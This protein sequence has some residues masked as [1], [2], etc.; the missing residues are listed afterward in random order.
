MHRTQLLLFQFLVQGL[1]LKFSIRSKRK[2]KL[3]NLS[4]ISCK[5]RKCYTK[6]TPAFM[7][8]IDCIVS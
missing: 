2:H 1:Q 4:S 7:L 3:E 6:Y 5:S 8:Q